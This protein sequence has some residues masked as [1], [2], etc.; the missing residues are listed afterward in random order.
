MII[1][2]AVAVVVWY[3]TNHFWG[4]TALFFV[5]WSEY[6]YAQGARDCVDEYEYAYPEDGLRCMIKSWPWFIGL[7]VIAYFICKHTMPWLL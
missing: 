2:L 4:L 3:F 1:G 6:F 7:A 5:I